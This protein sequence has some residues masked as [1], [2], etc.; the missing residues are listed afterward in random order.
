MERLGL[1]VIVDIVFQAND[2]NPD[3]LFVEVEDLNGCA[4]GVGEWVDVIAYGS[5]NRYRALRLD[6]N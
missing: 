6:V 5:T 3:L 1:R 2:E 4:V